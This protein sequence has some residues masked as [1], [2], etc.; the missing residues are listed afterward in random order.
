[1]TTATDSPE[2]KRLKTEIA[3][4]AEA[5]ADLLD[6]LEDLHGRLDELRFISTYDMPSDVL[7]ALEQQLPAW[8]CARWRA[9]A[10]LIEQ[11][12]EWCGVP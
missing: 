3:A 12:A 8:P 2:V 4:L 1:M 6:Q 5:N 9:L 11:R 10:R 7:Q